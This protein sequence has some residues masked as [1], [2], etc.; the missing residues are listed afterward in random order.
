MLDKSDKA[1]V[2]HKLEQMLN[3]L[4]GFMYHDYT[5]F[6]KSVDVKLDKL[7]SIFKSEI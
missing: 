1:F 3:D 4:K 2:V 7:V 5:V 6:H